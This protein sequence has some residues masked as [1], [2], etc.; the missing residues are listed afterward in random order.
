MRITE[1]CADCVLGVDYDGFVVKRVLMY[2][3]TRHLTRR[4][5][6]PLFPVVTVP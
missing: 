2:M 6:P 4:R 1:I 5:Q 3:L